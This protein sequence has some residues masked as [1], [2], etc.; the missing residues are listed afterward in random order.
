[1][2]AQERGEGETM[3]VRW[4][5]FVTRH[6]VKM[7]LASVVGLG[8]LAIPAMSLRLTLPDDSMASP[9][10]TQRVAYDTLSKGFGP[11]F[12]GPLTVVVDARDSDAPKRA[13]P[14][15]RTPCWASWTTSPPSAPPP[16]T[17]RGT[18]P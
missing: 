16:S 2:R 1:M 4:G 13:A 12:N 6:P 11:G 8:L 15:T 7:L 18:W 5:R 17:S 14:R 3:G 9:G 10:S